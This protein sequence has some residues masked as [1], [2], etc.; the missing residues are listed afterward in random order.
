MSEI[1]IEIKRCPRLW[2]DQIALYIKTILAKYD[3]QLNNTK[4]ILELKF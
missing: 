1:L 3:L 4:Y 2:I